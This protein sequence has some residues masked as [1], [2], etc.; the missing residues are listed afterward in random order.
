MAVSYPDLIGEYVANPDRYFTNGV[1]YAGYFDPAQIDQ[2]QVAHL[3]LFLK[4]TLNIPMAVEL[5][6]AVP[7]SGGFLRSGKEVLEIGNSKIAARLEEA[8]VGMVT[9]PVT[10]TEH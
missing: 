9:V 7:K 4:N 5:N 6:L 10:T 3:Y 8:E 2:G 1:Q